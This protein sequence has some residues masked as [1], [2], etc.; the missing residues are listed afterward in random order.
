MPAPQQ[1]QTPT[2]KETSNIKRFNTNYAQHD[3]RR[4]AG[5]ALARAL[6][7][8]TSVVADGAKRQKAKDLEEGKR[9]ALMG[10]ERDNVNEAASGR[11]IFSGVGGWTMQG[12][13]MQRGIEDAFVRQSELIQA[14]NSSGLSE[15]DDIGAFQAF[16]DQQREAIM[17]ELGDVPEYYREGFLEGIAPAFQKMGRSW[18]GSAETFRTRKKA[19]AFKERAR[20]NILTGAGSNRDLVGAAPR[21]SGISTTDAAKLSGEVVVEEVRK[22]TVSLEDINIGDYSKET[23]AELEEAA[24]AREDE[25]EALAHIE[26]RRR[27]TQ[28]ATLIARASTGEPEAL[29]ELQFEFPE[30]Y[31]RLIETMG[32]VDNHIN[33]ELAQQIHDVAISDPSYGT[34][35]MRDQI[36]DLY[37]GGDIDKKTYETLH[38]MNEDR[39]KYAGVIE[40]PTT[41][42]IIRRSGADVLEPTERAE[43]EAI[44][45]QE[46]KTH[47]EETG[48]YPR[49]SELYELSARVFSLMQSE[50]A[51]EEEQ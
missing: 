30:A 42:T 33:P 2:Y 12:F 3:P 28:Q 31:A 46:I 26:E 11:G 47:H 49:P 7:V 1:S 45:I 19:N 40:H 17:S 48:R 8:A 27:K 43:F 36:S 38:E 23:Q 50:A 5:T 18:A 29:Q 35:E 20:A 44:L 16:V 6:G 51:T 10:V 39:M 15:S 13:D 37:L 4:E 9:L 34:E 41:K 32:R 21:D 14:F 22:G 25:V 24:A